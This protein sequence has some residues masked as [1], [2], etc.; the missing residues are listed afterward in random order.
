MR[1]LFVTGDRNWNDP[2]PIMRAFDAVDPELVV[3]GDAPGADQLTRREASDRDISKQVFYANWQ[4]YRRGAGP[5]R[6]EKMC[7]RLVD[8]REKGH[9]VTCF[10]FHPDL[11]NKSKGTKDMTEKLQDAGF[12]YVYVR[13]DEHKEVSD[14]EETDGG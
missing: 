7:A 14:A 10:A 9:E 12:G 1:V 8:L 11:E 6:N 4:R 3:V 5:K 13:G 2:L